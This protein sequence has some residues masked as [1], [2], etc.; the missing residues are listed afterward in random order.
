M[1]KTLLQ[2]LGYGE[3]SRPMEWDHDNAK[4]INARRGGTPL[5]TAE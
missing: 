2:S 4:L 3:H 5:S 1:N